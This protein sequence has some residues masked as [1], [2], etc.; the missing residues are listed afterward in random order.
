MHRPAAC[1]D[2]G[3]TLTPR[4][5]CDY[6]HAT[7]TALSSFFCKFVNCYEFENAEPFVLWTSSLTFQIN[8]TA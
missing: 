5:R 2:T 8:N 6:T 1:T 4:D 7:K 3:D